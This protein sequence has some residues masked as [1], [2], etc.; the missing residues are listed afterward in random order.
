MKKVWHRWSA[1]W[2]SPGAISTPQWP[3]GRQD[4]RKT[5][6][7]DHP[8]L[9]QLSLQVK[10]TQE[11]SRWK[12]SEFRWGKG[13]QT[14]TSVAFSVLKKYYF[15]PRWLQSSSWLL[16]RIFVYIHSES[17][18]QQWISA[19]MISCILCL[20]FQTMLSGY[21]LCHDCWSPS[22]SVEMWSV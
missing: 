15:Q 17:W 21:Q 14:L 13:F 3:Q 5:N 12:V 19:R 16:M 20:L 2:A 9:S 8:V 10:I 1:D 4:N 7:A 22:Q 11:M 18:E 6:P